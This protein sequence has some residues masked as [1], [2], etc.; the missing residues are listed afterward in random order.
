MN[1]YFTNTKN[2][3][4][5]IFLITANYLYQFDLNITISLKYDNLPNIVKFIPF[6]KIYEVF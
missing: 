5:P 3:P 1:W 4:P 6:L 2:K